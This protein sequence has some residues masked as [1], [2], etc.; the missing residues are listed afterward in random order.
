MQQSVEICKEMLIQRGYTIKFQETQIPEQIS[1]II[2]FKAEKENFPL[3]CV[4]SHNF[5]KLNKKDLTK[6]LSSMQ[7]EN[8]THSIIIY[9]DSITTT[10]VKALGSAIGITVEL[11]KMRELSFNV[12]KHRLQP[13]SFYC[14]NSKETE[15]FKNEYGLKIPIIKSND[16]ICRFFNFPRSSIIEIEKQNGFVEYRIVK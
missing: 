8:C 3:I 4:Y 7:V 2:S 9:V 13:K 11:F 10:M 6:Y 5:S 1:N 15:A 16:I 12:T 14:L